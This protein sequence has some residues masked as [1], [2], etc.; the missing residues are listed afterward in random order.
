MTIEPTAFDQLHSLEWLY[1]NSNQ[2]KQ[3]PEQTFFSLTKT[4]M[5]LDL[6]GSF[7]PIRLFGT[8]QLNFADNPLVCKCDLLWYQQWIGDNSKN[9]MAKVWKETR[10]KMSA[11]AL[12][13]NDNRFVKEYLLEEVNDQ[14][15]CASIS[16]GCQ[17]V[18]FSILFIFLI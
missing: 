4:L 12:P 9:Q 1:L 10:C 2:L 18:L 17:L 6:H 15:K 5:I 7:P 13:T 8:N 11:D 14:L 3:I 16:K